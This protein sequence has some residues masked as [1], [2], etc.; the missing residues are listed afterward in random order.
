MPGTV[1][2]GSD[3][4][5]SVAV[6]TGPEGDKAKVVAD[7]YFGAGSKA[8]VYAI[9]AIGL[10]PDS[11]SS[12]YIFHG[13][14]VR[15]TATFGPAA[16]AAVAPPPAPAPLRSAGSPTPPARSC[17]ATASL[18]GRDASSGSATSTTTCTT[19]SSSATPDAHEPC[20][21]PRSSRLG[22]VSSTRCSARGPDPCFQRA[23]FRTVINHLMHQER[24]GVT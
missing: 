16:M 14:F 10:G 22:H 4:T 19:P 1:Y 11:S 24:S 15:L 9:N 3:G 17:W 20:A 12:D 21:R 7:A 5:I 2:R 6:E 8:D 18:S 13:P 23:Q